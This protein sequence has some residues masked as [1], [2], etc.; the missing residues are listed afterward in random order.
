MNEADQLKLLTKSAF[1]GHAHKLPNKNC[2][3]SRIEGWQTCVTANLAEDETMKM[4][5]FKFLWRRDDHKRV[6]TIPMRGVAGNIKQLIYLMADGR[7]SREN[8]GFTLDEWTKMLQ[9]K[10][11]QQDAI[12][13]QA[14]KQAEGNKPAQPEIQAVEATDVELQNNFDKLVNYMTTDYYAD[15]T[16]PGNA[17]EAYFKDVKASR[18]AMDKI[19]KTTHLF[20][21]DDLKANFLN[22][23]YGSWEAVIKAVKRL[24]GHDE[25]QETMMDHFAKLREIVKSSKRMETKVGKFRELI[26]KILVDSED[27]EDM[28]KG[29]DFPGDMTAYQTVPEKYSA[30]ANTMF[31]FMVFDKCI[32][33]DRWIPIQTEY[34][35]FL[36]NQTYKDWHENR[37]ELYKMIDRE[38]KKAGKMVGAVAQSVDSEGEI[39]WMNSKGRKSKSKQKFRQKQGSKN[40]YKNKNVAKSKNKPKRDSKSKWD[41]DLDR[42]EKLLRK[43]CRMCSSFAKK[44]ICHKSP[45]NGK[46]GS[47]C[48]YTKDGKRRNK[49]EAINEVDLDEDE[50]E[51]ESETEESSSEE[52]GINYATQSS[53]DSS[54]EDEDEGTWYDENDRIYGIRKG[55]KL[56]SFANDDGSE[57]I[58]A[59]I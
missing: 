33:T 48:L 32:P 45:Y 17:V 9:L 18:K 54:D 30:F 42:A 29:I 59:N 55:S 22:G 36:K 49:Y 19:H 35:G 2:S 37:P 31:Q 28:I 26:R 40:S 12:A 16:K 50:S 53:D 15:P 57:A 23:A 5:S 8:A 34:H 6:A 39:C 58:G 4:E 1:I 13:G 43:K 44:I 24:H 14:A 20:I 25:C 27:P 41:I 21:P 51:D 10:T 52:E 47:Q 56:P 11:W 46:P 38:T 7:I 3:E